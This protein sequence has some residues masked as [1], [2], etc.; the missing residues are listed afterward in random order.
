[1]ACASCNNEKGRNAD[2]KASDEYFDK[3]LEKRLEHWRE[4]GL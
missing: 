4:P 2:M 1:M 3:L